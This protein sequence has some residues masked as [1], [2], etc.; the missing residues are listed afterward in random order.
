MRGRVGRRKCQTSAGSKSFAIE[1]EGRECAF[2]AL[3]Q[4]SGVPRAEA[5]KKSHLYEESHKRGECGG[6]FCG[7]KTGLDIRTPLWRN[8]RSHQTP[9]RS[10]SRWNK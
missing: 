3:R 5:R 10:P 1:N 8:V 4:L 6:A 9:P 2:S 7:Q